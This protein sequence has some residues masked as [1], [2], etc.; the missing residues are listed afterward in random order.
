MGGFVGGVGLGC[1]ESD[2]DA[3]D[4]LDS[5]W[6]AYDQNKP[7]HPSRKNDSGAISCG[8]D[9]E[10]A[11]NAVANS[12]GRAAELPNAVDTRYTWRSGR[13]KRSRRAPMMPNIKP[14]TT[15]KMAPSGSRNKPCGS[16]GLARARTT[17]V[18]SRDGR[19]T[20]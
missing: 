4:I 6:R 17:F 11:N 14:T 19:K 8:K 10:F 7:V 20:L 12:N 13:D 5:K 18:N 3:V 2:G 16:V 1:G 15:W 9:G